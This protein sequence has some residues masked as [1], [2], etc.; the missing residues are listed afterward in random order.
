MP[1][2]L[3]LAF[4]LEVGQISDPIDTAFGYLIFHRISEETVTASHILVSFDGAMGSI[5]KRSRQAAKK[6]VGKILKDIN[7]G[8]WAINQLF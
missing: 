4:K 8:Y 3:R 6:L 2:F 7:Y 1:D 5:Q